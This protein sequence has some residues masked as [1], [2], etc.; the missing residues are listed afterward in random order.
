VEQLAWLKQHK[1]PTSSDHL[2][3]GVER[4]ISLVMLK[5]SKDICSYHQIE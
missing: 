1:S 2:H 5:L 3:Q 4:G